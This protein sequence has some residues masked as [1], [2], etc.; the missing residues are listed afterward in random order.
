[1]TFDL[2]KQHLEQVTQLQQE[3]S[4]LEQSLEES[5]ATHKLEMMVRPCMASQSRGD[6]QLAAF[7]TVLQESESCSWRQ[8]REKEAGNERKVS[9]GHLTDFRYCH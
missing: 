7:Q 6:I 3:C 9:I 4:R 2:S 1:M 8:L 5:A